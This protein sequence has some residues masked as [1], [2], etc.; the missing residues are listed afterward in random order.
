MFHYRSVVRD[1]AIGSVVMS[2]DNSDSGTGQIT[3]VRSLD[4]KDGAYFNYGLDDDEKI[5]EEKDVEQHEEVE[6]DFG[7]ASKCPQITAAFAGTE[8]EIVLFFRFHFCD[9]V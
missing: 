2:V 4:E 9:I 3:R 7:K 6:G 8:R 1:R 5:R